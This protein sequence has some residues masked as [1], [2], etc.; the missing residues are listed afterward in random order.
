MKEAKSKKA[1][2][3]L[4]IINQVCLEQLQT[5]QKNF[6]IINI[7]ELSAKS[8]GPSTQAIRNKSGHLY[9]SLIKTYAE[10]FKKEPTFNS[11]LNEHSWVN[12]IESPSARWLVRDLIADK[13]KLI[14]EVN[15]L[16]VDLL[17]AEVPVQVFDTAPLHSELNQLSN[18]ITLT[19]SEANAL[20]SSIDPKYLDMK[21][22]K[23]GEF[24]E[25]LDMN[26]FVIFKPGF[27]SA[28]EKT[29]KLNN[30]EEN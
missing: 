15:Q 30:S 25:I 14:A 6:S 3:S 23:T 10:T 20:K 5:G 4:K 28:I 27:F 8:L 17:N 12:D 9:H 21:G 26:D 29:L 11:R 24:G 18:T 16:K 7:G 1:K 19:S 2:Q 22:L 13:S